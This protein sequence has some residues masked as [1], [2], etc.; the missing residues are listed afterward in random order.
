LGI[1]FSSIF[2]T[3]PNQCNV[4]NLIR[5]LSNQT[6]GRWRSGS[7]GKSESYKGVNPDYKSWPFRLKV[8]QLAN[9]QQCKNMSVYPKYS[10]MIPQVMYMTPHKCTGLWYPRLRVRSRPKPSDFS[11]EKILSI[12]SFGREVKP[13]APCRR[14]AAC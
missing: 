8:L 6:K 13:F 10:G 11:G 9:S 14:F 3:C 1:L 2:C 12:P 5:T 7:C 4:C